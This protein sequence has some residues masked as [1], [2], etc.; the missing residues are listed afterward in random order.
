MMVKQS[1]YPNKPVVSFYEVPEQKPRKQVKG[2]CQYSDCKKP[3][4][5]YGLRWAC[6]ACGRSSNNSQ[7]TV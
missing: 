2:V 4:V 7:R 6:Q 1:Q 5:F 3:V